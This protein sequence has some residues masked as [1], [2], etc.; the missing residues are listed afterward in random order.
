MFS[1]PESTT[2]PEPVTLKEPVN[3]WI[4]S[5]VSPNLVE[6]LENII[7]DDTNSVWNSWAVTLPATVRFPLALILPITCNFSVGEVVPIPT[8]PKLLILNVSLRPPAPPLPL[9]NSCSITKS[10][11]PAY[12][13][14][15]PNFTPNLSVAATG[16]VLKNIAGP[17]PAA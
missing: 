4:S 7:E 17:D 14:W 6:P 2:N 1:V 16:L 11:V 8:L 3:W 10:A 15:A 5:N 9:S 13:L 12:C